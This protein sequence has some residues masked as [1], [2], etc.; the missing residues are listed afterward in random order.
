MRRLAPRSSTR[1]RA[2]GPRSWR[3]ARGR[4]ASPDGGVPRGAATGA[5]RAGAARLPRG[6][7][8]GNRRDERVRDGGGQAERQDGRPRQ[9]AG[10]ARGVLPGG[11]ASGSRRPA[12]RALS[13]REPRQGAARPLHQ[14]RR[15]VCGMAGRVAEALPTRRTGTPVRARC[16]AARGAHG[17]RRRA[18]A[19]G[20]GHLARAGVVEPAPAPP[21]RLAGRIA[22]GY[23]GRAAGRAG[24]RWGTPCEPAGASTATYGRTSRVTGAGGSG[25]SAIS[26]T[27]GAGATGSAA[28]RATR[29]ST[30]ASSTRSGL[31]RFARRGDPV[32]GADGR[33]AWAAPRARRS[34]TGR[35]RRRSQELLRRAPRVRGVRPH[36]A[37]RDPRADRRADQDGRLATSRGPYPVLSVAS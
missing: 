32:G 20:P 29:A 10:V 4:G 24:R 31:G 18:A 6:R 14:A 3:G 23:D 12:A 22:R 28:T 13:G 11:W 5:A 33:R 30:G 9:R 15:A 19:R 37:R 2:P 17:A 27:S 1:A 34:S 36:A 16:L 8:R 25:S 35:A 21:E 7:D 26:G